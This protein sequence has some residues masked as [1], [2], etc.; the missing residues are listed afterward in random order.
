MSHTIRALLFV[1]SCSITLL[2]ATSHANL[3]GALNEIFL[4]TSTATQAVETQRLRGIYG[5]SMTLRPM[6]RGVNIVQFAMPN[7][8]AGCGGIDIFFGSFSWISG[9]QFEQLLRS[10]ASA[11]VGYAIKAAI[12]Q[13][14]DPCEAILSELE[15][16]IRELNALAKN[17][18]AIGSAMF[19]QAAQ[20][21]LVERAR[22]IGNHLSSAAQKTADWVA[23][24]NKSQARKP[25]DDVAESVADENPM[26]G[27]LVYRAAKESL[28]N[29]A[30]TLNAFL[31]E[32]QAIEFIMGLYGTVVVLPNAVDDA[33]EDLNC[34]EGVT[35]ERC[36]IPAQYHGAT[37]PNWDVLFYPKQFTESGV[38][39]WQCGGTDCSKPITGLVD[40]S[41]WGGVK[42]AINMGLFGIPNP[43]E[44]GPAD[45]AHD[46]I[47][48]SI[49]QGSS[50]NL[51][52]RARDL[53]DILPGPIYMQLLDIQK[54]AGAVDM[55]G[56]Q[57][58]EILAPFFAYQMAIEF[59]GIGKNVFTKQTETSPP[60]EFLD[61]LREKSR[62]T[63]ALKPDPEDVFNLFNKISESVLNV[64]RF[65]SSPFTGGY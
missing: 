29:G 55:I 51:S 22:S 59:V 46:S 27:N 11:A 14:C 1:I 9:E 53:I 36:D 50:G 33:D 28:N 57:L 15:A 38:P 47:I 43:E 17:T 58:A 5:G 30:N 24:E 39:V 16:A 18:C 60:P 42:E 23:G 13:M 64:Q 65:T 49:L 21:K 62:M 44:T 40:F 7:I 31:T 48:G 4:S 12:A 35:D 54:S 20:E 8:D 34:G 3:E 6:S 61:E 63:A 41:E 2:P 25:S 56:K 10:L 19:N 52:D 45:Y 32:E 26:V 37:I